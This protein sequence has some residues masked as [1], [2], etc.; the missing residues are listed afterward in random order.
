MKI[1]INNECKKE[2]IKWEWRSHEQTKMS[3]TQTL[4]MGLRRKPFTVGLRGYEIYISSFGLKGTLWRYEG[5]DIEKGF[6]EHGN[7]A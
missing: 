3:G 5:Q 1:V 4:V 2:R 6:C 7:E